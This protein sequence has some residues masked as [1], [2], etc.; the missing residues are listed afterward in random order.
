MIEKIIANEFF[1]KFITAII[2]MLIINF[3]AN[4]FKEYISRRVTDAEQRYHLRKIITFAKYTLII[5]LFLIVFYQRLRGLTIAFGLVGAG[6]AFSLQEVIG[7]FAGWLSINSRNFYKIG[8]R[9]QLGNTK[10]D[11]IDISILRT[12]IMEVGEWV[13]ADLYTGRIVQI[14]NSFVFKSP[15]YNYSGD[16]PYLWDKIILPIQYGSNYELARKII[17][18]ALLDVVDKYIKEAKISW[19]NML[20][21]YLV[22]NAKIEPMV[23]LTANDNWVEYTGRY[24]IDYKQRVIIKD[25]LFTKILEEIQKTNG[26]VKIASNT[27][28][29]A[30]APPLNITMTKN[31]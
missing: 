11:V 26:Q 10:G 21:K 17:N 27:V 6:L 7:S 12:T 30:G 20:K 14:S 9:V 18:D 19:K 2:G 23:T 16:F 25:L 8:D 1:V 3:V 29:L 24:V 15:V 13:D 5:F 22:E 4:Y 31:E 28:Q